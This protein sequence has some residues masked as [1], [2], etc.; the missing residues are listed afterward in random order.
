MLNEIFR[1][2]IR[3]VHTA[4][5]FTA[6]MKRH[7]RFADEAA[8]GRPISHATMR[9]AYAEATGTAAAPRRAPAG[10]PEIV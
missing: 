4:A 10:Q 6:L 8:A 1:D 2:T 3:A 5:R 9:R 7:G